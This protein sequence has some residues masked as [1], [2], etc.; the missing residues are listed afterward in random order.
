MSKDDASGYSAE[1]LPIHLGDTEIVDGVIV[2]NQEVL[3]GQRR[4]APSGVIRGYSADTGKFLWAWDVKRPHEHGEL[5][6]SW[7]G[8]RAARRASWVPART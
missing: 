1:G 5:T 4:W 6:A 2:T 8:R 7:D 3:D